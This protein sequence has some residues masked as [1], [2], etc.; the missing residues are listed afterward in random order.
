[1]KI[2]NTINEAIEILDIQLSPEDKERIWDCSE[3]QFVARAHHTLGR[4]IRNEWGLWTGEGELCRR[5]N[6]VGID[7][8]DDMSSII[9][10]SYYRKRRNSSLKLEEQTR[11]YIEYWKARRVS[12]LLDGSS[13]IDFATLPE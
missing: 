7:H 13:W 11:H 3:V 6:Q 8:P 5:F 2:P 4:L 12:E 9:L 10:T 1:M